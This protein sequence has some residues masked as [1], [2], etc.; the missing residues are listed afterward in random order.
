MLNHDESRALF[1][2]AQ[3]ALAGGVSSEFRKSNSPHPL[4]YVRAHGARLVDADEN[5]YL[6]FA[7]SQGPMVLGHS[8]PEVLE[9][10]ERASH[11]GQLYAALHLAEIEL[12]EKL[13]EIIPCAELVRF[14]VSGSEADHAALRVARAVTGRQKF[15]RFEGHYHGWFDNVAFG[16]NGAS[17]EALGPHESPVAQPWTQGLP[18]SARDEFILLPWNDL[19]LAERTVAQRHDEIAAIITEPIMCNTGC[20]E[21]QPGYLEGLRALCDRYGIALIFDEVITGFRVHLGGAQAYYGV[22]PDLAVFAKAMANGYPISALVGRRKWMQPIAEGKVIHAGTANAGNPSVAAA[23]A[24]IEVMQR[25][26]VHDK[27]HRLGKRLQAGLR[28]AARETGHEV[29]VQGPG[30]VLNLAFTSLPCARDMRDT[31]AFDKAKLGRFAYGLQEEGV[32]ILSRGTWY[33]CAAHTE[34]DI[35]FAVRAARKVLAG[36]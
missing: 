32:R 15:I 5:E 17:L 24:T 27:L 20:I 14:S 21:P 30:P 11:D 8:H 19:A 13:Q 2:R 26:R 28:E 1:E 31:F 22:T 34:A 23:K 35:D 18:A 29:L 9:A 10:V 16:I 4:V 3:R 25:D 6:D 33:L 36:M 7:L 12:A